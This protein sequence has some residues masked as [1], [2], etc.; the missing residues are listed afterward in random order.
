MKRMLCLVTVLLLL[1]AL[2]ACGAVPAEPT[3]EPTTIP[4]TEPTTI[5][6]EPTEPDTSWQTS[7]PK[8]LSYEEYFSETRI[9]SYIT[10]P[11][12]NFWKVNGDRTPGAVYNGDSAGEAYCLQLDQQGLHIT[13]YNT[14]KTLWTVPGTKVGKLSSGSSS[15]PRPAMPTGSS[16][17]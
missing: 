4:T 12:T 15:P 17:H 8:V 11:Y 13:S 3:T 9:F 1:L 10:G 7:V 16:K 2:G 6:T 14:Q 5:P